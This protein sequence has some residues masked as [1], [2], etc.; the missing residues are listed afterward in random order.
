MLGC[1]YWDGKHGTDWYKIYRS[2]AEGVLAKKV[3]V[4]NNPQ[5]RYAEFLV[6]DDYDDQKLYKHSDTAP[7]CYSGLGDFKIFLKSKDKL[8]IHPIIC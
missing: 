8:K 4:S 7:S 2:V 1:N 5:R 6:C 3:L